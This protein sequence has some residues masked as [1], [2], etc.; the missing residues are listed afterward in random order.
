MRSAVLT[1][2]LALVPFL[3]AACATSTQ[4]ATPP[5]RD[6]VNDC[7]YRVPE[8]TPTPDLTAPMETTPAS[9]GPVGTTPETPSADDAPYPD[10]PPPALPSSI[11]AWQEAVVR[12]SVELAD[13]RVRDQQGLIVAQRSVLTVLDFTE[14]VAS[15]SVG[16]SGRGTLAAELERFDPRTGAALLTVDIAD[17]PVVLGVQATVS[18]GEP[19]LLLSRGLDGDGLAVKETYASPSRNAPD[20]IFALRADYTTRTERGT[21]VVATDG[22]P[23]PATFGR[24]GHLC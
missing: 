19:V 23:P 4:T 16:V 18:N 2:S 22:T 20:H 13:G 6:L 24:L 14:E 7:S 8:P 11:E 10:L 1:A 17:L 15:L 12:V 9:T 21:V 5:P 3:V